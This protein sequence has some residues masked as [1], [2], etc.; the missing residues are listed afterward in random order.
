VISVIALI[1]FLIV[2]NWKEKKEFE[3]ELNDDYPWH[4]GE[5][6]DIEIDEIMKSAH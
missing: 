4:T 5:N 2:K 1:V 6:D 3:Q